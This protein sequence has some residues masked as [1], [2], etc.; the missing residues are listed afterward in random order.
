M[1]TARKQSSANLYHAIARGTGQQIIFEDDGDYKKFLDLLKTETKSE[2][3]ELYAWCLMSNHIHLLVHA[4]LE[5]LAL[6]MKHLLSNYAL[7][8]NKK[9]GRMGHLFQ[10]RYTSVPVNDNTSLLTEIRY[11]HQNPVKAH[12]ADVDK[13]PWSSYQ[14]YVQGDGICSLEFPLG[15]FGN[16]ETYRQFHEIVPSGE[17]NPLDV[18]ARQNRIRSLPDEKAAAYAQK[19]LGGTKLDEVKRLTRAERDICLVLLKLSGFSIRR[20]ARLTGIGRGTIQRAGGPKPPS[21]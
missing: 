21:P 15:V 12:L 18:V 1:R 8:F 11:I 3:F 5:A 13:Y 17:E 4:D 9:S 14:E 20:I 7:Y 6:G 10:G 19:L 16:L 2:D